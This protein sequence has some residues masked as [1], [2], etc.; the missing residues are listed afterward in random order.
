MSL[1]WIEVKDNQFIELETQQTL[2]LHDY[3]MQAA[4]SRDM[5]VPPQYE[6]KIILVIGTR[7]GE[8]VYDAEIKGSL[9]K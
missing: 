3:P 9:L 8:H 7:S 6:G 2:K 1:I 5:E 4:V